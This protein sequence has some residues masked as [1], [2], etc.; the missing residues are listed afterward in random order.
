ME[1]RIPDEYRPGFVELR[2]LGNNQA[3]ELIS[4][5]EEVQPVRRRASLYAKVASEAKNI[6]RTKLYDILDALISLFGLRDDMSV[7]TPEFARAALRTRWRE[8]GT[9]T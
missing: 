5:L 8:A 9:K 3:R 1:I 2:T 7:T 6:E 4:V